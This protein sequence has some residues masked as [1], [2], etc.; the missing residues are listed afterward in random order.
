MAD[1]PTKEIT[2]LLVR[3]G[4][5]A[6]EAAR[7]NGGSLGSRSTKD[8]I[9]PCLTEEGHEQ[10][11]EAFAQIA[12]FLES[13]R[14]AI[15]VSPLQR[16][17]ATAVMVGMCEGVNVHVPPCDEEGDD[18]RPAVIPLVV[19]NG[20]CD[21]AAHVLMVGGAY[22]AIQAG[23]VDCAVMT[24]NDGSIDSPL[25]RMLD[26]I[27]ALQNLKRPIQFYKEHGNSFIAMSHPM[28]G[29]AGNDGLR[30]SQQESAND[31]LSTAPTIPLD[32][33]RA[34]HS[35]IDHL[36]TKTMD[37]IVHIANRY[38]CDVCIVVTHREGIHDLIARTKKRSEGVKTP[39]CCIAKFVAQVP[40]G[41]RVVWRFDE[42]VPYK[43]FEAIS[44]A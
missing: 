10:A 30:T 24:A 2:V 17:M 1:G 22:R 32:S 38:D 23:F 41:S 34:A 35:E 31:V 8:R 43:A 29:S 20:L 27:P 28:G 6:D 11:K 3:H 36:F 5:R 16:T 26:Q 33:A 37:R 44:R 15:F 14:A 9:D 25:V 13:K 18:A 4:E 12:P 21:C 7:I 40:E 19:M 42:V 39:Y